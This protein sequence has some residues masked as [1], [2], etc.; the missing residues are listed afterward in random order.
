MGGTGKG[1][2]KWEEWGDEKW[3]L[4]RGD[5][6]GETLERGE[7][8]RERGKGRG[9]RNGKM[10][11]GEGEEGGEGGKGK[12]REGNLLPTAEGI[13]A[14]V[15]AEIGSHCRHRHESERLDE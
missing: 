12:G 10:G 7:G 14:L 13:D 1:K 5:W 11:E 3:G 15:V 4:K 9:E 2:E 8:K 6:K